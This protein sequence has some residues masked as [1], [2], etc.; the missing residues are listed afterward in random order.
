MTLSADKEGAIDILPL[1]SI[2]FNM[3]VVLEDLDF[4]LSALAKKISVSQFL[5]RLSADDG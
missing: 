4:G 1:H 5:G 2:R 3:A